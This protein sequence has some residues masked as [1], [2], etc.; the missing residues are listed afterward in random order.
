MW[1][2]TALIFSSARDGMSMYVPGPDSS[3]CASDEFSRPSE[4]TMMRPL[5]AVKEASFSSSTAVL[6]ASTSAVPPAGYGRSHWPC[7]PERHLSMLAMSFITGW[8]RFMDMEASMITTVSASSLYDAQRTMSSPG[9]L[10]ARTSR[11]ATLCVP[12]RFFGGIGACSRTRA[13]LDV[14]TSGLYPLA[15]ATPPGRTSLLFL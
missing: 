8:W 12:K 3:F 2:A 15:L 1:S 10:K 14:C 4:S 13:L 11:N 9:V 7:V 5:S 6:T